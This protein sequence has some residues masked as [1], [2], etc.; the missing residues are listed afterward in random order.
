MIDFAF[1]CR[2]SKADRHGYSPIE[3]SVT[4][5]HQ[6][7][8][9]QL[10][11]KE[12]ASE[13]AKLTASKKNND[14]KVYLDNTRVLL[15]KA[16]TELR[17]ASIDVTPDN[18]KEYVRYGELRAYT[19]SEVIDMYLKKQY[20]KVQAGECKDCVYKKYVI[21]ANH[22][23]NHVGKYTEIAAITPAQIESF[24]FKMKS[25]YVEST[26]AGQMFRLKYVFNFAEENGIIK[27]N[28]FKIKINCP[29]AKMEYLTEEEI[30]CIR[31]A[32][33]PN[34]SLSR[35][36]DLFLFQAASGLSYADMA[37]F[38][39]E[40]IKVSEN[41]VKYIHKER[42]KTGVFYTSVLLPDAIDML[43]K[44]NYQLPLISNQ[45][46]NAYLK[47]IQDIIGIS[48]KLHTHLA[49][50]TYATTLLNSGCR[51]DVVAK[52]V[53]HV[54]TRITAQTYAFMQ[55]NTV[56]DEIA[57]TVNIVSNKI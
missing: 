3:V 25:V 30:S 12:R 47:C 26:L 52:A 2:A 19:I 20:Q 11:R 24:Y 44:Y 57:N 17:M 9:F 55:K 56:V 22:F 32:N 4:I 6:R 23:M 8:I 33:I 21:I 45:K 34:E 54:N 1:Y 36:R 53:G 5:N 29:K 27:N 16:V 14:L 37:V 39:K 18:I 15:N 43:E 35:V 41:G 46:Y 7:K 31:H 13:Y 51:L 48:K 49:R 10:D 40:D 50:K 28:P 42:C 38:T